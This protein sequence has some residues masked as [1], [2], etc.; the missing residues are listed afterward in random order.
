[1]SIFCEQCKGTDFHEYWCIAIDAL[2]ENLKAKDAEIAALREGLVELSHGCY[3][4]CGCDDIA[5]DAL[6]KADEIKG[7]K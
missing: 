5:K 7:K 1:M 2:T 6:S 4:E 3:P